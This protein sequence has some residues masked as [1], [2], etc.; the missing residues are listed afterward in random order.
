MRGLYLMIALLSWRAA[1]QTPIQKGEAEYSDEARLAGLEGTVQITF[2]VAD[3]GTPSDLQVAK[4]LGLG[5]DE[6]ALEAAKQ[7]HFRTGADQPSRLLI[8]VE[9][10]LPDKRSRWHL[11]SVSFDPPKGASRPLFLSATYPLGSGLALDVEPSP[12]DEARIVAAVGRQAWAIVSFDVDEKGIPRDFEALDA[13]VDLWKN[14]AI[15]LVRQWRFTP[16]MKDGK[17]ISVRC[18]LELIW[19]QRN[20]SAAQLAQVPPADAQEQSPP[21]Q[22]PILPVVFPPPAPGVARI[23]LSPSA[24]FDHLIK[25]V[26]PKFPASA[27]QTGMGGVVVFEV[28]IGTDGHVKQAVAINKDSAFVPEAIQALMQWVYRPEMLNG[29]AAEVTTTVPIEVPLRKNLPK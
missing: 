27:S 19:G 7:W 22:P 13:S 2:T 29:Q 17:P 10:L 1:A 18:T 3:D 23:V 5:L 4:P 16:G 21:P 6:K 20:L 15:A 12:I 9:F 25:G 24:Q 14:Q 26:A 11:T 28:L 8:S